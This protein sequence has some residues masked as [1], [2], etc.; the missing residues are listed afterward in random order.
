MKQISIGKFPLGHELVELFVMP[1]A[2]D[3]E[4]YFCPDE[5]SIGQIA[6]GLNFKLWDECVSVLLH[7]SFEYCADRMRLRFSHTG[8]ISRSI[9][10]IFIFMDHSQFCECC[11]RVSM[12]MVEALPVLSRHYKKYRIKNAC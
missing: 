9:D 10:D 12:F 4:F 1:D 6:V 2:T 11:C 5:K 3:G 8:A 7:E